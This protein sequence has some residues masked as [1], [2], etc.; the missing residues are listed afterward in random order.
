MLAP[1]RADSISPGAGGAYSPDSLLAASSGD[2]SSQ[3]QEAGGA[4]R[5]R[6]KVRAG[7]THE[8]PPAS[9]SCLALLPAEAARARAGARRADNP[10]PPG[11]LLF[12]AYGQLSRFLNSLS[13]Q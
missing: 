11:R 8:P 1:A 4:L 9:C 6:G 5:W 13:R 2:R 3:L 7:A 12:V 10:A